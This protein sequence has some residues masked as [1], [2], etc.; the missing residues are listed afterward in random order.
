MQRE[1]QAL[2]IDNAAVRERAVLQA[3]KI[4]AMMDTLEARERQCNADFDTI[5]R[6]KDKLEEREMV[7]TASAYAHHVTPHQ[8]T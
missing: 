6:G 5:R 3:S 2:R 8:R 4:G 7:R 1:C